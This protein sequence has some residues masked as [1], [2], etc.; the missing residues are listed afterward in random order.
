MPDDRILSV[1]AAFD[2]GPSAATTGG[3]RVVL[4]WFEELKRLAPTT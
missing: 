1:S 3:V 2:D 4:D